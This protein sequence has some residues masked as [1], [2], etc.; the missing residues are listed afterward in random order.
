M[1]RR[2]AA[3]SQP[4][5]A[6]LLCLPLSLAVA[7]VEA[8]P[9]PTR[10]SPTSDTYHDTQVSDPY[11][12]LE[13]ATSPEVKQWSK[14]QNGIARSFLDSLPR[15]PELRQEI[16]RI[17]SHQAASFSGVKLVNGKVFAMMRQPPKQQRAE[18]SWALTI[19]GPCRR[20]VRA[21]YG[22][23]RVR[24]DPQHW[25]N[26]RFADYYGARSV[27]VVAP[28]AGADSEADRPAH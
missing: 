6:I 19:G 26:R 9:P 12:W 24:N 18:A 10:L 15:V 13:D 4:I 8:A 11:R 23:F 27:R 7:R 2:L 28:D 5:W 3:V 20:I 25:A 17:L 1:N 16:T 21:F 14:M 22:W